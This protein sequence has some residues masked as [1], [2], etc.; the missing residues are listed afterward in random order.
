[1][2]TGNG[3]DDATVEPLFPAGQEPEETIELDGTEAW[4]STET[5]GPDQLGPAES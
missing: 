5:I 3:R 4:L 1:M 2:S